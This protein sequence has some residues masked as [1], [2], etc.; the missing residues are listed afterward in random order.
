M[1]AMSKFTVQQKEA[2]L[3]ISR[4]YN[5]S[6]H[7]IVNRGGAEDISIKSSEEGKILDDFADKVCALV[8]RDYPDYLGR[9]ED[10]NA[11]AQMVVGMISKV[12]A[13]YQSTR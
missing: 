13:E 11:D 7:E 9:D 12:L 5:P 6:V 8:G 2:L 4:L 3:H 1:F 10:I